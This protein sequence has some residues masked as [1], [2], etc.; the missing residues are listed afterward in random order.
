MG[1][2]FGGAKKSSDGR[3]ARL[4]PR[5]VKHFGSADHFF[6]PPTLEVAHSSA[7]VLSGANQKMNKNCRVLVTLAFMA[8][9]A[10]PLTAAAQAPP[11]NRDVSRI[12]SSQ[13]Q[14]LYDLDVL[15]SWAFDEFAP[16]RPI[17]PINGVRAPW[18][19][20]T[21]NCEPQRSI[22]IDP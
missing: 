12:W 21:L 15:R 7:L 4:K 18:S 1:S 10:L 22:S 2:A 6:E 16:L 13:H 5:P 8:I 3:D 17:S 14:A 11:R 20:D 9:C 19:E